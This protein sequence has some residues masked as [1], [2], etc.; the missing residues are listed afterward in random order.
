MT[1][2]QTQILKNKK[3]ANVS[4]TANNWQLLTQNKTN[5]PTNK[6]SNKEAETV[7]V[8]KCFVSLVSFKD[9]AAAVESTQSV[10]AIVVLVLIHAV[11]SS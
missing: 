5:E 6:Q 11:H 2:E 7:K 9:R 3:K 8:K 1:Q 10:A 4:G